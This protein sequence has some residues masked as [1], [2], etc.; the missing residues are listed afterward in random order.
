MNARRERWRRWALPGLRL[1]VG[2]WRRRPDTGRGPSGTPPRWASARALATTRE[3]A[4]LAWPIAA[5]ML[6]E[7]A[8]GLVDTRLVGV[9]GAHAL[10]G[11]GV[12]TVLMY[13]GYALVFGLMR[14]VKVRTA[15]AVGEGRA[16]DGHAYAL[17]GVVLGVGLGVVVWAAA[18]DATRA[19]EA[20]GMTG[21]A[22]R[23]ARD[24]LAAR[25]FGAPAAFVVAALTQHRQGAGDSRTPMRVTLAGNVVNALLAWALIHGH[26]GLP[27]LGVAGAG[28]GTAMTEWL[29]AT[30]LLALFAR[31]ARRDRGGARLPV[32]AAAREVVAIG[33]PTGLHFAL[34][35]LGFTAF[36]AVLG[37][38][39]AAEIAAHHVAL[40]VV[41][42]S[43]LPG[44]AVAEAGCVLVGRAL[45]RGR[46]AEAERA[47]RS[48]LVLAVGFMSTC[49][50]LFALFGGAVARVFTT[51]LAVVVVVRRLLVV[52][53]VFQALDA[54]Y[55]VLRAALRGA[56]DVRWVAVVGTTLCWTCLPGAGWLFARTLGFGAVGAW[57]GFVIETA[58]GAALLW[59]RFRRG[60]WRAPY[61]RARGRVAAAGTV[62][63][64][65]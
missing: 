18:R 32:R 48:A 6:G 59:H 4:T 54:T 50:V 57:C 55:A 28:Y 30:V 36:T 22:A 43:F 42:A 29:N 8:M 49:G 33:G 40:N 61:E 21:D 45:G 23:A 31:D 1:A 46:L 20:L 15:Y 2:G 3:L 27:A 39:G 53:A 51:D 35:T 12:G 25:T 14:G 65:V 58:V 64:A 34:E 62:V 7:T 9:L 26:F 41:R 19:V 44:M 10:A 16:R 63:V 17:A 60:P 37:G 52:A 47:T 13:L 11:V 38:L 5:A 24:F 56:K